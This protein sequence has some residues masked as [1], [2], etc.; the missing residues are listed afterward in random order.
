MDR[1]W[2]FTP[3]AWAFCSLVNCKMSPKI[4]LYTTPRMVMSSS[5]RITVFPFLSGTL[6]GYTLIYI[7]VWEPCFVN[8]CAFWLM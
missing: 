8:R 5:F 3:R 6:V 1:L 2:A 4:L 7:I